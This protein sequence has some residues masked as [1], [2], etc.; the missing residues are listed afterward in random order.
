[1]AESFTVDKMRQDPSDPDLIIGK[2]MSKLKQYN[3]Q[4]AKESFASLDLRRMTKFMLTN[5]Y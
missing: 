2:K 1:M 5:M 4:E 3:I